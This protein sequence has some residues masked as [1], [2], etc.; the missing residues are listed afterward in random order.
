M[1]GETSAREETGAERRGE[2]EEKPVTCA[3][4]RSDEM[5]EAGETVRRAAASEMPGER[6]EAER[7]EEAGAK[8]GEGARRA[9]APETPGETGA[10]ERP[11]P[12]AQERT[13]ET[14]EA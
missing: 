10:E 12:A 9:G 14:E 6:G 13:G 11:V 5:P 2:R 7:A 3:Q 8:E 1:Q 4:G